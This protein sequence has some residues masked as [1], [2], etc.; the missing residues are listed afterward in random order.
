MPVAARIARYTKRS[1][2]N[3]RRSACLDC[4]RGQLQHPL[5]AAG[6]HPSGPGRA[7]LRLHRGSHVCAGYAARD[8]DR[9]TGAAAAPLAIFN[10]KARPA[11][12]NVGG[13]WMNF[14]GPTTQAPGQSR[15]RGLQ[16]GTR[17]FGAEA[18][19]AWFQRSR[20]SSFAR[21]CAPQ[22]AGLHPAADP[23][24]AKEIQCRRNNCRLCPVLLERINA[25]ADCPVSEPVD[26]FA[27]RPV[28]DA[29]GGLRKWGHQ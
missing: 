29:H 16:L 25:R 10:A 20:Q 14:A 19:T 4:W 15:S 13:G 7:F 12:I 28:T 23:V 1:G 5:A 18:A 9:A 22:I 11:L 26:A 21:S 2:S 27:A 6:H 17:Q 8:A 24:S 3:E